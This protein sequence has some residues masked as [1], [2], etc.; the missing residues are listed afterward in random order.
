MNFADLVGSLSVVIERSE[1]FVL[2]IYV[3]IIM[4]NEEAF[5]LE[6]DNYGDLLITQSGGNSVVDKDMEIDDDDGLF[7]GLKEDDFQSPMQS[8]VQQRGIENAEYSDISEAEFE[9]I[10][11]NR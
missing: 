1:S 7:S 3:G 8:L 11:A 6:D 2:S 9:D 10:G 5:S 4:A